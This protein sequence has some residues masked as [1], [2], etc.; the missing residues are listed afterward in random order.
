MLWIPKRRFS[1]IVWAN[2]DS[3]ASGAAPAIALLALDAH[4]GF[5]RVDWVE[6]YVIRDCRSLR[7]SLTTQL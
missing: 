1:L 4:F 7:L 3:A 5:E 6:R 2:V